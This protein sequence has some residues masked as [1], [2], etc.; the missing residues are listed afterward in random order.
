M[1]IERKLDPPDHAD[2]ED[3]CV[4]A[5]RLTTL[6]ARLE[7]ESQRSNEAMS[8]IQ[9]QRNIQ[10]GTAQHRHRSRGEQVVA[11]L[12]DL[13]GRADFGHQEHGGQDVL[14]QASRRDM[15][16]LAD[17]EPDGSPMATEFLYHAHLLAERGQAEV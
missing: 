11:A 6:E 9:T 16:E 4:A 14:D 7:Q 1:S 13:A 10:A 8:G 15:V 3:I 2:A 17:T 12:G 5:E